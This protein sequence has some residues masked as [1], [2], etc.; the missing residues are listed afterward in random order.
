[1]AFL[2]TSFL[3]GDMFA[4]IYF[5]GL[6]EAGGLKT[7]NTFVIIY[8]DTQFI[9]PSIYI[10]SYNYLFSSYLSIAPIY[11]SLNLI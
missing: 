11:L 9:Y 5:F 4:R 10:H 8:L 7:Q 6:T 3:A 2:S 1:M